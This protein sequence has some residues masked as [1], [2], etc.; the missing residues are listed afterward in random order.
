MLGR[1]WGLVKYVLG[2]R[3]WE[4]PHSHQCSSR[5]AH[6]CSQCTSVSGPTSAW[7]RGVRNP[8]N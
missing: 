5:G 3:K 7:E 2:T 1:G 6:T 8:Q 4:G